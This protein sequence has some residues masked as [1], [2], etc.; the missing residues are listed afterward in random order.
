[1]IIVTLTWWENLSLLYMLDFSAALYTIDHTIF[2]LERWKLFGVRSKELSLKLINFYLTNA[3]KATV[4]ITHKLDV[5]AKYGLPHGS[6]LVPLLFIH[7]SPCRNYKFLWFLK[8]YDYTL[9]VLWS[10]V[11]YP[12]G[13][14]I[15][16]LINYLDRI[17]NNSKLPIKYL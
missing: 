1:M 9:I 6:V 5:V 15:Q 7:R 4:N 8:P 14:L 16:L 12:R 13:T 10:I 11:M 17:I 3:Y 2:L